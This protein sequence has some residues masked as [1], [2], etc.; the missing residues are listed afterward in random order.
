MDSCA[1]LKPYGIEINGS[2][3]GFNNFLYGWKHQQQ[4]TTPR[5]L[6]RG[7][8]FFLEI[9]HFIVFK[10]VKMMLV[11]TDL[12]LTL[13]PRLI[14]SKRIFCWL[15]PLWWYT[16]QNQISP[17]FFTIFIYC[18]AAV[19]SVY[20]TQTAQTT[21]QTTDYTVRYTATA[22]S[23]NTTEVCKHQNSS[24]YQAATEYKFNTK[25]QTGKV[26]LSVQFLLFL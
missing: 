4:I 14:W 11:V 25:P 9:H 18:K 19:L 13:V 1:K 20:M 15:F 8:F 24:S 5:L 23:R 17:F 6:L 12:F 2:T 10:G 21:R 7:D 16:L 3:D 22:T 26:L